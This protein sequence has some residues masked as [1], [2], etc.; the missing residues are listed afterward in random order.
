MDY[1]IAHTYFACLTLDWTLEGAIIAVWQLTFD[2]PKLWQRRA[3][4]KLIPSWHIH[5][6]DYIRLQQLSANQGANLIMSRVAW[7][8]ATHVNNSTRGGKHCKKK[9]NKIKLFLIT[10]THYLCLIL[11][12]TLTELKSLV[13]QSAY[14]LFSNYMIKKKLANI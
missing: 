3:V 14:P 4:N 7:L 11:F 13:S 6:L 8:S 5:T 2:A 10:P 9:N 1:Y 12:Y